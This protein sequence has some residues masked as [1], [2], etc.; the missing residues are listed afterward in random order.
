MI[1]LYTYLS[2][3]IFLLVNIYPLLDFNIAYLVLNML[4]KFSKILE[5][6]VSA[7]PCI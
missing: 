1:I 6:I 5:A 4:N 7:V 2:I 3:I